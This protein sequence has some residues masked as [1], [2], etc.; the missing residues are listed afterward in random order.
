MVRAVDPYPERTADLGHFERTVEMGRAL[1]SN[2]EGQQ[3]RAVSC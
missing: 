3:L 2:D 1:V